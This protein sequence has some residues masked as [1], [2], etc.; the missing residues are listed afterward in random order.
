MVGV[1]SGSLPH[2]I[3]CGQHIYSSNQP[4]NNLIKIDGGN[5]GTHLIA[6]GILGVGFCYVASTPITVMHVGRNDKSTPE[7]HIRYLWLSWITILLATLTGNINF[8]GKNPITEWIFV[9]IGILF[10]KF[11]TREEFQRGQ[12]AATQ[13]I[14]PILAW[15]IIMSAM[16]GRFIGNFGITKPEWWV[17]SMPVLWVCLGQYMALYRIL[18]NKEKLLDFYRKL[19]K[20]R[21]THNSRD[22]R[23]T[24]THLREHSNSIFIVTI[25]ISLISLL[26]AIQQ[27]LPQSNSIGLI[28]EKT[29]WI[30]ISII[31]IWILPTVFMW[32][33]ANDL[34]KDF[35]ENAI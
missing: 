16:L 31:L 19:S 17:T 7:K 4:K 14:V 11:S 20:A 26:I 24:Y 28:D 21:R 25:E 33:R 1:I 22:I 32:S 35:S 8:L 5:I 6:I 12:A 3:N 34:E 10:L 27:T 13:F 23:D 18:N 2:R 29:G 15:A 30:T 9:L